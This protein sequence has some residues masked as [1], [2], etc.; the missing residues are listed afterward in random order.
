MKKILIILFLLF[1]SS[2]IAKNA[3]A[4]EIL[5]I[6]LIENLPFIKIDVENIKV[7]VLLDT[8]ARNQTLVLKDT[9]LS[10]LSSIKQ[11]PKKEKSIDIT[12]KEYIATKYIL[13]ELKIGSLSYL[14]VKVT[15]D[16]NWG[17][18]SGNSHAI[19]NK[20][21]VI[22]LEM[23]TDKA[24][25]L[26]YLNKKLVIIDKKYPPEYDIEN[27]NELKFKVDRNGVYI[28]ASIDNAKSSKFIIDTGSNISL[29]KPNLVDIKEK[30]DDC[31]VM[32]AIENKLCIHFIPDSFN[33]GDINFGKILLY[34]Y[35]FKEFEPDGIL[36]YDFLSDKMLYIDF[37]KRVI[38]VKL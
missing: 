22:G 19:T 21:G 5:D 15:E 25:I 16:T 27:W 14:Q 3:P 8:G 17:L 23:F 37:N 29:I 11:Y 1:E 35:N 9:I 6:E 18:S 26:D 13:P 28:F 24:I 36:G 7:K 38:K 10:K 32:S 2:V 33:Q 34:L 20:D 30:K 31:G 4:Y 12:G